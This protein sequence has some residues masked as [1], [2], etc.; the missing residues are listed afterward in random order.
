MKLE[1]W[2]ERNKRRLHVC[3]ETW[4]G[5]VHMSFDR[6]SQDKA[7]IFISEMVS[8][9]LDG[10]VAKLR[11]SK[12]K[13]LLNLVLIW[14]CLQIAEVM[15]LKKMSLAFSNIFHMF[16]LCFAWVQ[17]KVK[18]GRSWY[19]MVLSLFDYGVSSLSRKAEFE[20]IMIFKMKPNRV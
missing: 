8:F 1:D 7:Y 13:C 18:W 9:G 19:T 12:L 5:R 2:E 3:S 14:C 10:Q 16:I 20:D 6:Y 17:A 15:V 4:W 11:L